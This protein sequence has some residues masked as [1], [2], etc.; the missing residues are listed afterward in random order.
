MEYYNDILCLSGSEAIK[1][2]NNPKGI[3]TA[4]MWKKWVRDGAEVVRRACY[5][6]PSLIAFNTIP[7]KYRNMFIEAFGSP[8]EQATVKPFKDKVIADPI[9]VTFFSSYVKADGNHLDGKYI[10]EYSANAAV[11]N[12]IKEIYTNAYTSRKALG[13]SLI[14]F[15]EKAVVAV[16]NVRS[17]FGHTLPAQSIPLKRRYLLY[18]EKGYDSLISGKFCNNNS[19]KVSS[20]ME[21]LIMSLYT[22][23]NKPFQSTVHSLYLQFISGNIQVA[24]RKTGEIFSP[25]QFIH[26]NKPLEISESTIRSY[27]NQ[28]NNS[29][30][31]SKA[32]SGTHRYNSTIRP[33]HHRHAPQFSFSKITM[34]DRDLPRKCINGK[35]V[36]A[37]YSY[38]VTSG[39]VIGAAYSLNKDETLFLDC[40]RDMFRLIDREGFGMPLEVEVENH[41][42]SKFFDE[43]GIMFPF[44]RICNPG[45]SQEKHAEHLNRAK[46]YGIE[47]LTQTGIGRWWSK[48]EAYT[49]DR[50]KVNDEFVEKMFTYERLVADDMQACK[51]FNN[52]LHPKQKRFPGKTRWQVLVENMNPKAAQVSKAVVYKGIGEFTRTTINRNQYVSVQNEKYQLPGIGIMDKLL[53]NNYTVEAY[54]LPDA[55][56]V[57]T[58][59]FLYQQ[60]VYLCKADKIITYNTA[61]GEWTQQDK[62]GFIHQS[63]YVSQFDSHTKQGKNNLIT[64][65]IIKSDVIR[66]ALEQPVVHVP[67]VE[68]KAE[69]TEDLLDQY[70][71]DDYAQNAIDNL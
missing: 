71:P 5:G 4:S 61:K 36:K 31:V 8:T 34:D 53:P 41:L 1:S 19:R 68:V 11:L 27:L 60:G 55:D 21:R 43:L 14:N 51:D 10:K 65:I 45:N 48:H 15:W 46:K 42:V 70:N 12:A 2:S 67:E 63:K 64:P 39:C 38:D 59:V 22:M 26:N 17:E 54:Y 20:E 37:Y 18:I 30:I 29:M 9:A 28:P 13:G 57:I 7:L 32:R 16:N 49:V 66:T 24:D 35:W 3:V 40:M 62:D 52:Q 6:Q 69:T 25:S 44:V 47:K 56:G 58:E 50:D 33:H 23:P